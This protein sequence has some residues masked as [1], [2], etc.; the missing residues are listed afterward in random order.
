MSL[1]VPEKVGNF[2][3][4]QATT[5][6]SETPTCRVNYLVKVLVLIQFG[7]LRNYINAKTFTMLS[8]NVL[9]IISIF[10]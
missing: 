8:E 3:T 2:L 4:S 5:S 7:I 10:P 9:E 6:L 1:L